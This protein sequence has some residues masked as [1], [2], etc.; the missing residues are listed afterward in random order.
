MTSQDEQSL[1]TQPHKSR[2][3][4]TSDDNEEKGTLNN[5]RPRENYHSVESS[6]KEVPSDD[7]DNNNNQRV[8]QNNQEG[9]QLDSLE[10]PQADEHPREGVLEKKR[11]SPHRHDTRS[12]AD[13]VVALGRNASFYLNSIKEIIENV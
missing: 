1:S 13:E 6:H 2:E 10:I 4:F 3:E 8:K 5:K 11:G 12:H 7:I 9:K